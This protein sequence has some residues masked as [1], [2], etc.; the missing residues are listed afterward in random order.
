MEHIQREEISRADEGHCS[1]PSTEVSIPG[2]GSPHPETSHCTVG[3]QHVHSPI[4]TQLDLCTL[5]LIVSQYVSK[6]N[7]TAILESG[8]AKSK[9]P[10]R[11]DTAE[12]LTFS[13][14]SDGDIGTPELLKPRVTEEYMLEIEMLQ[15]QVLVCRFVGNVGIKSTQLVC[16]TKVER[17]QQEHWINTKAIIEHMTRAYQL[18][19][20]R[21]TGSSGSLRVRKQQR[22]HSA[23]TAT[24]HAPAS[25]SSGSQNG[26]HHTRNTSFDRLY[27]HRATNNSKEQT[28]GQNGGS[29]RPS[30]AA[31][32]G[33][34]SSRTENGRH[35]T[36]RASFDR[37]SQHR[38]TNNSKEQ[39]RGQNGGSPH[40][41]TASSSGSAS[42]SPSN[43][44][45]SEPHPNAPE[46][47]SLQGHWILCGDRGG[48]ANWLFSLDIVG[49]LVVDATGDVLDLC[50]DGDK[51][52]LLEGGHL[53][54]LGPHLCRVGRNGRTLRW[55]LRV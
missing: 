32:S 25:S 29:S 46:L 13:L 4:S 38:A 20:C 39:T 23:N 52:I 2:S 36:R 40:P 15:I 17:A 6:L 53:T 42:C 31:S 14:F 18:D 55:M 3:A 34:R 30:A 44:C 1:S 22:K 51:R 24:S 49:H 19:Q 47:A 50:Q 41:S 26:S 12:S 16:R 21:S 7:C 33:S 8:Q 28:H 43:D 27:Q 9:I 45:K 10:N 11:S 37:S 54:R 35:H 48:V 5:Q